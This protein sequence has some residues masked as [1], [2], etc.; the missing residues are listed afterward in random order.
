MKNKNDARNKTM[1]ELFKAGYTYAELASEN[2]L[3][4][5]RVRKILRAAGVS[6]SEGGLF[7][8]A[9]LDSNPN[10]HYEWRRK[11]DSE[12]SSDPVPYLTDE[13]EMVRNLRIASYA[14]DQELEKKRP[15]IA[16]GLLAWL[17]NPFKG[18]NHGK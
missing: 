12:P 1:V 5:S 4:L 10:D 13:M 3:S 16:E 17:F 18:P 2:E 11:P 8:R 7:V 9:R 15:S 14:F 6:D